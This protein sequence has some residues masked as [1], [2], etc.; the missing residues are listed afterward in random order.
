MKKLVILSFLLGVCLGVSAQ[1]PNMPPQGSVSV[2]SLKSEVLGTTRQFSVYVPKSF[3][4]SPERKYPVLYLLHGVFDN[5]NGWVMRGHLQDAANRIIDAGDARE[6]IIV[7]PDAGRGWNG[8]FDMDGWNY[9]TFFFTELMPFVEKK[10]RVKGDKPNRAIAGLSMGGGGTTVYAQKHPERFASAY[11]MSALMGLP[12]GGGL[13]AFDKKMAELNRT[14]I[15]NHCVRFVANADDTAKEKLRSV[16]WFVDCGDDDFLFD[17]NIEF[18]QAMRKAQI[19][20]QLRVRDGGHDWEYW[21]SALYNALPF[22][23]ATFD[24]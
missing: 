13:P 20:C 12:D 23:S 18:C 22:V 6:M 14:V 2:D 21:H 16:R 19:P 8:Y 10:Y 1:F 4:T 3:A 9:E 7:V 15:A 5:N 11:A 17:V 24:R